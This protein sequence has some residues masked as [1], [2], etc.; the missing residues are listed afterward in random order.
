[1]VRVKFVPDPTVTELG[2]D[3]RGPAGGIIDEEPGA[4]PR[5]LLVPG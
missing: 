2:W 5:L 4:L 1:M 3:A